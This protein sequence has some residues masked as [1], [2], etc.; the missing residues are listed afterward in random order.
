MARKQAISTRIK[1]VLKDA[2]LTVETA[3]GDR[4]SHDWE[5]IEGYDEAVPDT[6]KLAIIE[7]RYDIPNEVTYD[8][9]VLIAQAVAEHAG[10]DVGSLVIEESNITASRTETPEERDARVI[11]V[12]KV[13]EEERKAEENRDLNR[14]IGDLER[15]LNNNRGRGALVSGDILT[16]EAIIKRLKDKRQ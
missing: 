12:T 6:K 11:A 8:E 10:V 1:G 4:G 16:I 3:P 7:S 2:L 9:M 5:Y 15:T 13:L 14:T